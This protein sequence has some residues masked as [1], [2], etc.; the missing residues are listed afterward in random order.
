[1]SICLFPFLYFIIFLI[2][3][4]LLYDYGSYFLPYLN[5]V[6]KSAVI[7]ME[8]LF[9]YIAI[10]IFFLRLIVQNVRLIFMIFTYSELHELVIFYSFNSNLIIGN[11]SLINSWQ[12]L[13]NVINSKSFSFVFDLFTK[14]LNWLYELFHTFFMII[15]Q[16]IAFFAMVF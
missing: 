10:S 2:P 7:L 11:E 3:L 4:N 15:F 14:A 1:M 8:L 13:K 6:G 5:G 9:D 12:S 16:F